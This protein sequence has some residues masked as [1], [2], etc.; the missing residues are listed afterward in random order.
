MKSTSRLVAVPLLSLGL[1]VP[2]HA[3]PGD[4]IGMA[5]SP[6]NLHTAWV[7]HR[8]GTED[9]VRSASLDLCQSESSSPCTFAGYST[10]CMILELVNDHWLVG[11]GPT[12]HGAVDG[13][14]D[15]VRTTFNVPA[16]ET[17]SVPAPDSDAHCAWDTR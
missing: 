4:M 8:N 10:E 11:Y 6:S 14:V 2:A 13:L 3:D 12:R 15:T 5:Y 1:A 16:D 7:T 9:G 17:V